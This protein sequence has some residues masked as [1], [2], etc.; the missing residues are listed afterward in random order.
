MISLFKLKYLVKWIL[1]LFFQS[2]IIRII[3]WVETLVTHY[4]QGGPVWVSSQHYNLLEQLIPIRRTTFGLN[5]KFKGLQCLLVRKFS[6]FER[7]FFVESCSWR[8]FSKCWISR[9]C[10]DKLKLHEKLF[11]ST[12]NIEG[13]VWL[14]N[15]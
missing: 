9:T 4:T 6:I 1:S 11:D 14:Q 13:A 2:S 5:L 3:V 8:Y 7:V 12:R 15:W 10:Q